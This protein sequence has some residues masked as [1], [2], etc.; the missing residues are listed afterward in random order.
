MLR[1]SGMALKKQAAP[2][3][4][5]S[6]EAKEIVA[7]VRR[8]GGWAGGGP[9]E[10]ASEGPR[11]RR[12]GHRRLGSHHW[13]HRWA[14]RPQHPGDDQKQGRAAGVNARAGRAYR[15]WPRPGSACATIALNWWTY[16]EGLLQ[17]HVAR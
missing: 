3:R 12:F 13:P 4:W 1:S 16:K 11:A 10:R 2:K 14:G 8:A 6:K 9:R 17:R 5:R 7:A 15:S